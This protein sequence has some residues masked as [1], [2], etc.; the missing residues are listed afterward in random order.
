MTNLEFLELILADTSRIVS[1]ISVG[2]AWE[3]WMQV[4]LAILLRND[5]KQVARE[6]PY[7]RP[8]DSLMLDLLAQDSG[9]DRY[10]IELKCES[11]TN[12]GTAAG[13]PLMTALQQDAAK[14][15]NYDVE[16][17]AAKWAVGIAYS[18]FAKS[19]F[20][21]YASQFPDAVITGEG[22]SGSGGDVCVI[23]INAAAL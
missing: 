11:A 3:V 9:G 17:L 5:G 18:S 20:T 7:P 22:V 6:V 10:A 21:D 13:R 19:R 4:E 23:V 15:R 14:I 2:A 16:S 1:A 8:F 12:A